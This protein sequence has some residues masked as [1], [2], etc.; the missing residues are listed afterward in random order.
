[1]LQF[2]KWISVI[3]LKLKFRINRMYSAKIVQKVPVLPYYI[4]N[5]K[6][7]FALIILILI[8]SSCSFFKSSKIS[9]CYNGYFVNDTT[10]PSNGNIKITFL[11]TSALLIDD[12]TI[13]ILTDP[14]FS[15]HCPWPVVFSKISTNKTAV[16]TIF[17]QFNMDRLKAIIVSHSHYDHA[18]DIGY[19]AEK[20][21][22]PL[23]GSASTLNIARASEI[24]DFKLI[25][26][27]LCK[28]FEIG[29]FQ[30]C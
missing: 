18:F 12:G 5:F 20:T 4:S 6:L 3:E 21:N 22:V 19:V 15:R 16:D 13:Q 23:Y 29:N 30:I 9:T 2:K 27:K 28:K 24:S 1:M 7:S 26:F 10:T 14:F 11:G 25:H 17:K 8:S